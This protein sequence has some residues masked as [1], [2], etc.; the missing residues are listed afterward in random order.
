MNQHSTLGSYPNLK[1]Q[2][3]RLK[4]HRTAKSCTKIALVNGSPFLCSLSQSDE[5][6]RKLISVQTW[7]NNFQ[8]DLNGSSLSGRLHLPSFYISANEAQAEKRRLIK[9]GKFGNFHLS[10]MTLQL[11]A[12]RK[13][14]FLPIHTSVARKS[15]DA[16]SSLNCRKYSIKSIRLRWWVSSTPISLM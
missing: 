8:K 12:E 10:L 16:T 15:V 11:N 9:R 2:N 13:H 1:R 6:S 4:S 7:K 14:N 5:N 3:E